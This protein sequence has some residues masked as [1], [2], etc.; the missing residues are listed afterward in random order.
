MN[1]REKDRLAR[2]NKLK[3][4]F[5]KV[6]EEK[7]TINY[8][9]LIASLTFDFGLS[10]SLAEM[11]VNTTVAY[12]NGEVKDGDIELPDEKEGYFINGFLL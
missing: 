7:K 11:D 3:K 2:L 9:R 4:L 8:E 1:Q 10:R 5:I 12:F 6:R